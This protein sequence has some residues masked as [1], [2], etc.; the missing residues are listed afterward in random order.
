[1]RWTV[2]AGGLLLALAVAFLAVGPQRV[3]ADLQRLLGYV[4]GVGFVNLEETRVLT[5]PVTVTR[6]GVTLRVEEVLAAPDGTTVV[7]SSEGLPPED[8]VVDGSRD[9]R[10]MSLA[11]S[12]SGCRTAPG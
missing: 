7:I 8:E 2:G 4:P 3:W 10:A 5:A 9:P 11:A 12:S 6:D 1:M